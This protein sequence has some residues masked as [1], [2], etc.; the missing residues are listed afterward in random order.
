MLKTLLSLAVVV[1][2][3]GEAFAVI[4]APVNDPNTGF[5]L[6]QVIDAG[7]IR[8]GDKVFDQFTISTS[9]SENA[10][11]PGA[12]AITVYGV[13]IA[14]G[15]PLP[16]IGL[17]FTGGWSAVG[18]QIA[19]TVLVFRV[20][21]DEPFRIVDNSLWMD[22]YGASGQ[23]NVAI[24]ENVFSQSPSDGF[25]PS[26][27]DKHVFFKDRNEQQLFDHEE[28]TDQEGDPVSLS[29]IWVVKDVVVNGGGALEGSAA[30]SQFWQTFSQIPEPASMLLLGAGSLIALI[31]RRRR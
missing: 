15:D 2:V 26:V 3:A 27:A 28:F 30:L 25:T 31:R 20:T 1:L 17:R 4:I 23:G 6:Q 14:M 9:K 16:E 21:A 29:A 12:E 22:A 5:T 8:V 7:G 24:T 10:I 19:D 11:A 18:G 13:S